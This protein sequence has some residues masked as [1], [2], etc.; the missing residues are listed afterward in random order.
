MTDIVYPVKVLDDLRELRYSL[1][2]I[3]ANAQGLYDK[4][5]IVTNDKLPNWLVN[6]EVIRAG[7]GGTK[8]NDV[9][10]KI[11]SVCNH[12]EVSNEFVLMCD[13]FYLVDPITE[14]ETWHMGPSSAF[15]VR[16]RRSRAAAGWLRGVSETA[17]WMKKQG[18]GDILTYQGHRPVLWNKDKL[19]AA[20][21][22]YP[23]G[24][25]LDI[26]GLYPMAGAGGEG[27]EGINSKIKSN[28]GFHEKVDNGVIP[29]LSSNNNSFKDGMIGGYIMGMFRQPCRYEQQ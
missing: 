22:E 6:V 13:D 18:Y 28:K 3:E 29:W 14:W 26:N 17:E 12:P 11:L 5:W 16:Q 19:G 24:K 15:V 1:R 8:A 21:K 20:I 2:S 9:R 25:V 23:K 4:I 10:S 27:T 7:A